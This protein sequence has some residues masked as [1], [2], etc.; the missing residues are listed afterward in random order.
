MK[1]RIAC[2]L[3]PNNRIQATCSTA[4]R[5]RKRLMRDVMRIELITELPAHREQH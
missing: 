4:A 1:V 5:L 3:P 2:N